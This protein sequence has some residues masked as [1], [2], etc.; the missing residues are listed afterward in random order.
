MKSVPDRWSRI[1]ML[2][3]G[4]QPSHVNM[5]SGHIKRAR[6]LFLRTKIAAD[7]NQKRKSQC[8]GTIESSLFPSALSNETD[9]HDYSS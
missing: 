1:S 3:R 6:N 8:I 5:E 2:R 7:P 4:I 9:S